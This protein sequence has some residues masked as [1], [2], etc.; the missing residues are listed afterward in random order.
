[1][2]KNYVLRWSLFGCAVALMLPR[3]A[4]A[5]MVDYGALQSLF[6]ESVTTSAT[7][8]PQLASDVPTNMT[9]IT[10]DEIRQSGSRNIPEILSRVPG[11]DILQGSSTSFDVG[12]RGY[13]QA[14][15][16]R[17]LVL[18]DGRQVF[19]DDYSRTI[20]DN[21]PV[22]V[23]DIRQIEVVKG[24]SSALFG[25]NAASGVVNIITYS[26]LYDDNNVASVNAGTQ[27]TI[28]GDTTVTSK[29]THDTNFR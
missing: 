5:Q 24:A 2:K 26:P 12:T 27:N 28:E 14:S 3:P 7:G 10:A 20:W 8:T 6:G 1:M 13:Q 25:S 9:I 19:I 15:Q 23:D 18:I 21:L 11:M 4:V 17:L 22:N 29:G 16:P